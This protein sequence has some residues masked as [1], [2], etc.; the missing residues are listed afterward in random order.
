MGSNNFVVPPSSPPFMSVGGGAT[1]TDQS[2]SSLYIVD[3]S[4]VAASVGCTENIGGSY[5]ATTCTRLPQ[6]AQAQKGML[7]CQKTKPPEQKH[8]PRSFWHQCSSLRRILRVLRHTHQ[9]S[10]HQ[11]LHS[12]SDPI[13]VF[14]EEVLKLFLVKIFSTFGWTR[15]LDS[16][17]TG[18]NSG[19]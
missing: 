4:N 14:L 16:T 2:N 5:L 12:T 11:N 3:R 6:L 1:T 10:Y 8:E 15:R 7:P 9:H 17:S 19:Q 18:Q 13:L